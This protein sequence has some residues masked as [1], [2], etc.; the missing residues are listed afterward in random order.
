MALDLQGENYK[1]Q[2]EKIR[3]EQKAT[4]E[5]DVNLTGVG[6]SAKVQKGWFSAIAYVKKKWKGDVE[7]GAKVTLG[8]D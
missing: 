7:A 4:V 1:K 3:D 2:I 5:A 6:I 8:G